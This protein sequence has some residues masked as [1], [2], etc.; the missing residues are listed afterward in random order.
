MVNCHKYHSLRFEI[1]SSD[2]V[3][4]FVEVHPLLMNRSNKDKQGTVVKKAAGRPRK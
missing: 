2:F 4:F 3:N 1:N